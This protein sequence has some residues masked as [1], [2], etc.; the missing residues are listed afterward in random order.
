[1]VP[2]CWPVPVGVVARCKLCSVG[3]V[4]RAPVVGWPSLIQHIRQLD[5]FAVLH[6]VNENPPSRPFG[7][8][9]DALN[10]RRA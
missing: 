9:I 10:Q 1:M 7:D 6:S 2:G 3:I 4:D 8:D 5:R